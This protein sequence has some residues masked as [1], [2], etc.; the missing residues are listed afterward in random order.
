METNQKGFIWNFYF[1]MTGL[2]SLLCWN[3][4]LNYSLYFETKVSI[5]L[6]QDYLFAYG[7]GGLLSFLLSPYIFS[8]LSSRQTILLSI[9][10]IAVSFFGT[11]FIC[12]SNL[13]VDVITYF[14]NFL[15]GLTGYFGSLF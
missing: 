12:D 4:V 2:M 7:F 10:V 14:S 6:L 8:S 11:I 1:I 5:S 13:S 3:V 15:I 9:T